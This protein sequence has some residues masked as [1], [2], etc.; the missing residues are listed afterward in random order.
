MGLQKWFSFFA[1]FIDNDDNICVRV[2]GTDCK[3]PKPHNSAPGTRKE[4]FVFF[5][6][7]KYVG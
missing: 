3:R 5:D 6:P 1:S 4:Y 2:S 7:G